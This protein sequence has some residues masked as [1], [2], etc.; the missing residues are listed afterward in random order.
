MRVRQ[1]AFNKN[2]SENINIM[3]ALMEQTNIRTK[4]PNLFLY[5]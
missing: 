2:K 1:D 3:T 5:V 4:C